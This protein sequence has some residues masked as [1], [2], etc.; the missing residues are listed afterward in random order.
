MTHNSLLD[1]NEQLFLVQFHLGC[2]A[3]ILRNLQQL[4]LMFVGVA[5]ISEVVPKNAR[6]VANSGGQKSPGYHLILEKQ[7][8]N[9]FFQNLFS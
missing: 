9:T 3:C 8:D 5:L 6:P 7:Y 2:C 4:H 1:S